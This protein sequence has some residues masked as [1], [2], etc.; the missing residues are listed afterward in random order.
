MTLIVMCQAG[1]SDVSPD[2]SRFETQDIEIDGRVLRV[3][4]V[5]GPGE[6]PMVVFE[7]NGRGLTSSDHELAWHAGERYCQQYGS[8]L[9]GIARRYLR[10]PEVWSLQ[11]CEP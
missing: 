2:Q 3:Q 6:L 7:P 4:P 9:R 5:G 10:E 11:G 1:C 8:V